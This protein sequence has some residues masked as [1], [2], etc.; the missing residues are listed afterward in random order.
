MRNKFYLHIF[1][2][3]FVFVHASNLYHS[4]E[5]LHSRECKSMLNQQSIVDHP[6]SGYN[7]EMMRNKLYTSNMG[8]VR[9][10]GNIERWSRRTTSRENCT[11]VSHEPRGSYTIYEVVS[12]CYVRS[13]EQ[14]GEN[15]A[16]ECCFCR[17]SRTSCLFSSFSATF[18]ACQRALN[19]FP[20]RMD[21]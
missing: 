6:V 15:W 1:K 13:R 14:A 7:T 5:N 19:F 20:S 11:R 2:K 12:R 8:N 17:Y 18:R 3:T 10:M 16:E 4:V 9:D 21:N